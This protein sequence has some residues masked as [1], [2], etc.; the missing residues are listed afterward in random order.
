MA[1][2]L[3]KELLKPFNPLDESL[4]GRLN[5]VYFGFKK[6]DELRR[7]AEANS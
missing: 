5:E 4:Q 3:L 7:D 1:F 2:V 6:V